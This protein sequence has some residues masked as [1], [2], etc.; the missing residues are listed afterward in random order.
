MHQH[1][2]GEM[3]MTPTHTKEA[4]EAKRKR[5]NVKEKHNPFLRKSRKRGISSLCSRT[6]MNIMG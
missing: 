4:K 1:A 5:K 3:Q 6:K 2:Q